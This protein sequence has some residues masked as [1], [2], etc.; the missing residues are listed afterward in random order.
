MLSGKMAAE[1]I[2]AAGLDPKSHTHTLSLSTG[3]RSEASCRPGALF[4][5]FITLEPSVE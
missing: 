2:Q 1:A 4:F 3:A 5:F